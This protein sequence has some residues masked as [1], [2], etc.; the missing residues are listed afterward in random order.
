MV[1][2][3]RDADAVELVARKTGGNVWV[4][5]HSEY[6]EV[7]EA[8]RADHVRLHLREDGEAWTLAAY[9]TAW[10]RELTFSVADDDETATAADREKAAAMRRLREFG[11]VFHGL[12]KNAVCMLVEAGCSYAQVAA[13]VEM[14]EAMVAHYAKDVEKRRLAV[15]GMRRLEE[16]WKQT[17]ELLFGKAADRM[18]GNGR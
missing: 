5:I 2:P 14:S 4:P 1:R 10:Q 15:A 11:L 16:G 6:R 18:H 13:I 12:R 3:R 7:L 8:V 17:R 9:R